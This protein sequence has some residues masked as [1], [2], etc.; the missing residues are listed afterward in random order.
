LE[1][2][3]L[4]DSHCGVDGGFHHN[5]LSIQSLE[6]TCFLSHALLNTPLDQKQGVQHVEQPEQLNDVS[7]ADGF[8]EHVGRHVTGG[9]M[10]QFNKAIADQVT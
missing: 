2:H 4:A 7:P 3:F 9:V 5:F 8:G 1:F 10:A 6:E